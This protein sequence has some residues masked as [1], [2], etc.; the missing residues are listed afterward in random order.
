MDRS[1]PIGNSEG[2]DDRGRLHV[3]V[4]N[5]QTEPIPVYQ[6]GSATNTTPQ[7]FNISCPV[8]NQEYSIALP[9]NCTE[10][11]IQARK[12]STVL[13]A[14]SAASPTYW[15]IWPGGFHKDQNF[16]TSQTIYFRCSKPDEII[17]VV[18]YS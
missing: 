7:I 18:T 17:E 2:T 8:A 14:Y 15:T 13:F 1:K 11:F 10:F 12:S 3:K 5:Q 6:T 9:A 16:Y 4:A